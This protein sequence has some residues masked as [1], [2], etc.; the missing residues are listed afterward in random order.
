MMSL[1]SAEKGSDCRV[2]W[3][4]GEYVEALK[5]QFNVR[6]NTILYVLQNLSGSVCVRTPEGRTLGMSPEVSRRIKVVCI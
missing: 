1:A 6:E 3:M 2:I 5:A 4:L